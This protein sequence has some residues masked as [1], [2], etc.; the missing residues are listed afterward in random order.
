MIILL[1][2]AARPIPRVSVCSCLIAAFESM[3]PMDL[4]RSSNISGLKDTVCASI[5]EI[6]PSIGR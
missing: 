6:E 1:I 2:F 3:N 5:F 4:N